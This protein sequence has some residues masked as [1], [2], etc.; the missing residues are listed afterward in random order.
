M[1]HLQCFKDQDW[2]F[3]S[4][5]KCDR[6]Q[7]CLEE[8]S[9]VIWVLDFLAIKLPGILILPF[10]PFSRWEEEKPNSVGAVVLL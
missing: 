8:K 6:A 3:R 4:K 7:K 2:L 10:H 5:D 9:G 1:H